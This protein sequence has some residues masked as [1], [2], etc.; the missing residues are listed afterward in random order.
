MP[1]KGFYGFFLA[2]SSDWETTFQERI[3]PKSIETDMKKLHMKFSA[4]N[5]DFDGS[6]LDFLRSWK[7]A[8]EGIKKRYPCKSC[9]FTVDGQFFMKTV[10]D[11]HGHAAYHSKHFL[12]F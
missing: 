1:K 9:F 5:V 2:K 3:A 8:L 12:A 10:V 6:S 7:H 4:L 11:K